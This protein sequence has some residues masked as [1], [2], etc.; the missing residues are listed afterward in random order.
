MR[1]LVTGATGFLGKKLCDLLSR[2]GHDVVGLSRH[3]DQFPIPAFKL[4][5]YSMGQPFPNE[6]IEFAPEVIVNLAWQGIPDFSQTQC[7]QN[8]KSHSDF[9]LETEKFGSLKK[10]IVAGTCRE[11]ATRSG[12]CLEGELSRPDNYFSWAKL[13]LHDLYLLSLKGRG[14]KLIWFRIF[15]VYG[16]GQRNESLI[17]SLINNFKLKKILKVNNPLAANDFIYV[18]DVIDGFVKAVENVNSEGIL[19]LGS[20]LPFTVKGVSELVGYFMGDTKKSP[21]HILRENEALD[22]R[23]VDIYADLRLVNQ[24]L[25]WSPQTDLVSGIKQTCLEIGAY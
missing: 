25:D 5:S 11:Y 4:I 8:F 10:V 9:L 6:L 17:P 14:I 7:L 24:V 21:Q 19:N 15:Y 1:I 2:R 23:G 13:A 16:P 20:G 3:I 18:D 22:C 12:P